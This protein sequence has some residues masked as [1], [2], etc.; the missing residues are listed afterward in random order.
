MQ[1]P[2][3]VNQYELDGTYIRT[4][5][6]VQ[7]AQKAG[8]SSRNISRNACYNGSAHAGGY[9]WRFADCPYKYGTEH[10]KN[11]DKEKT[12]ARVKEMSKSN[13]NRFGL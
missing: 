8:V 2:K 10:A 11:Y 5:D 6:S 12:I 7:E 4:F 3:K 13:F 1:Q 9:L